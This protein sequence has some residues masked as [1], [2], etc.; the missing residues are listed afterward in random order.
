MA[1]SE[2]LISK[3]T[4]EY[5]SD[6]SKITAAST[7]DDLTATKYTLA[8]TQTFFTD[9]KKTKAWIGDL[10]Y[11]MNNALG[12]NTKF[13]RYDLG[14]SYLSPA[15]SDC[16]WTGKLSY[17]S[18]TYPDASSGRKDSGTTLTLTLIQPLSDSLTAVYSAATSN[19][20]SN[21]SDY[22]YNKFT[23]TALLSWSGIF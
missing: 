11:A 19:N 16:T 13:N 7:D 15:F 20:A 10:S 21:V 2:D 23:L 8:T 12:K 1:T 18:S 4:F 3:Y 17:F 14:G 9:D 5:R 22:Q 6:A